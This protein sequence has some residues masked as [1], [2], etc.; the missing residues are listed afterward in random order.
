MISAHSTRLRVAP[1]L[2]LLLLLPPPPAAAAG[3][4]GSTAAAS[5]L[6]AALSLPELAA[7][8]ELEAAYKGHV[9]G[10]G[11]GAK[12]LRGSCGRGRIQHFLGHTVVM[13][14]HRFEVTLGTLQNIHKRQLPFSSPC[15]AYIHPNPKL[16]HRWNQQC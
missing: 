10:R 15:P 12:V 1:R 9:K 3:A 6:I 5:L 4:V 13:R 16:G 8:C 14:A 7:R 2:L 11:A